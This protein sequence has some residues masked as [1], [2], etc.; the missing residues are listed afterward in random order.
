M[1]KAER[2]S[3]SLT[4]DKVQPPNDPAVYGLITATIA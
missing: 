2:S 1:E 4:V 3:N